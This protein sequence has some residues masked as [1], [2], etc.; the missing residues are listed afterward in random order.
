MIF[1][2]RYACRRLGRSPVF[3]AIAV[4]SLALGIGANSAIFN[5]IHAAILD[6][7]PVRDVGRLY[8]LR[9]NYPREASAR[10]FSYP[11]YKQ[12]R[13][14]AGFEDLLCSFPVSLSLSG[15]G[16]AERVSGSLV[17]G[18]YFQ[19]LGVGAHIGRLITAAD[20]RVRGGHP[21]AV[22]GFDFWKSRFGGDPGIVGKD[23]L[24]NGHP[25]TVIGVLQP[26]YEGLE[27]G[28][29][30]GVYAPMMTKALLTPGW[31]ALD[32]TEAN[33]LWIVGRLKAGVTREQ[34][35]AMADAIYH[36][37]RSAE[38][39]AI[40][41]LTAH[42]LDIELSGRIALRPLRDGGIGF[43][44]RKPLLILMGIVGLLLLIVCINVANL[45]LARAAQNQKETAVRLA[46]GAGRGRL[47]VQCLAE[48]ILLSGAGAV[49]GVL[50]SIWINQ[51]LLR[52]AVSP[53]IVTA[54]N[55]EPGWSVLL[56]TAAVS[57][58]AAVLF[59]LAP[60]WAAWKLDLNASL[61]ALVG[62]QSRAQ[63]ALV[64][65]QIALALSLVVAAT[66]FTGTLGKLRAVDLGFPAENLLLASI[67]PALDGYTHEQRRAFAAQLEQRLA[68]LPGVG[69][70]SVASVATLSGDD[71]GML[72][73]PEGSERDFNPNGNAV[74]PGYFE[75]M[76]IPIV[77]G[78]SF[79]WHDSRASQP[80][81]IVNQ[82]VARE[83]F[84]SDNPIG[85]RF[86]DEKDPRKAHVFEIVGVAKDIRYQRPQEKETRMFVY[87]PYQQMDDTFR[88]TVL[89]VRAVGDA[90]K[91]AA[92]VE[93]E[94]HALDA[95]LPVFAVKTQQM[96]IGEMLA[97]ERLIALLSGL[98]GALATL[99]AAMGLYGVM[100]YA[101]A[102]RT[103]EMGIRMALGASAG[104][105]TALVLGETAKLVAVGC[106]IGLPVA[107]WLARFAQSLLYDMQSD[108]V[109]IFLGAA[110]VLLIVGLAAGLLPARRAAR[111]EPVAALRVE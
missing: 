29:R 60:A 48:G 61:K 81:A 58:G 5:L 103:R 19:L 96:Q 41:G 27:T 35:G 109:R 20:D 95:N 74:G 10:G 73:I 101:V 83:I 39:R 78:R 65:A 50:L 99:L 14:V 26:G 66:L 86:R 11:F 46:L 38:I 9:V 32:R 13:T 17:S 36:G 6:T 47:A 62:S 18:N 94:V 12:M 100:A 108:D 88:E 90:T 4:A 3:T 59:S 53:D 89:H 104:D 72:V 43:A 2:F 30:Q 24:L 67:D 37:A 70:A 71:W 69:A 91:L 111:M 84:G 85:K 98:F 110:L 22:V 82:T 31:D 102:R 63:E 55:L 76:R 80:V 64:T 57:T 45:L 77:L 87:V 97:R 16:M 42:Q 107:F 92:A 7:V 79:T 25:F 105:V 8:W 15:G 44:F 51:A 106:A 33:W 49:M 1:E 56:F 75:T 28:A 40:P 68:A 52:F 21:V 23:I 54:L 34:A 93:R